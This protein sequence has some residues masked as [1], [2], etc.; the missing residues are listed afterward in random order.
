MDV[1]GETE[2]GVRFASVVVRDNVVGFQFHP[3]KSQ[4]NG[5]RLLE[6]FCNWDGAC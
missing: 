4:I 6:N 1:L 5:L 3:E 2:Y